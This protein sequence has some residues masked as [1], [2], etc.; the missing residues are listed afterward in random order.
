MN[1]TVLQRKAISVK[2]S[3]MGKI[4]EKK[5]EL[6][7]RI[8]F[9]LH[10]HDMKQQ[11]IYGALN[12]KLQQYCSCGEQSTFQWD[13][14]LPEPEFMDAISNAKAIKNTPVTHTTSLIIK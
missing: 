8:Y 9:K 10:K 3:N 1:K 6:P 4:I 7:S 2:Y 12:L 13:L 11:V 5:I 14:P